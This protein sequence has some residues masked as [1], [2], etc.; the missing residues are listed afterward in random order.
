MTDLVFN[1]IHVEFISYFLEPGRGP[2]VWDTWVHEYT[3]VEKNATGDVA[4]DSY[5]RYKEDVQLLKNLGVKKIIFNV[6][7]FGN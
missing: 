5:H 2:S 7:H 1:C 4:C 6:Y 3:H